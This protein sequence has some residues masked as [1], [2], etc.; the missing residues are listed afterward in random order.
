MVPGGGVSTPPW[1]HPSARASRWWPYH[2]LT[3]AASL[4]DIRAASLDMALLPLPVPVSPLLEPLPVPCVGHKAL[5]GGPQ[6]SSP[7]LPGGAAG[8]SPPL[9]NRVGARMVLP[10]EDVGL[11]RLLAWGGQLLTV[12]DG[13][14][15]WY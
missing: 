10:G 14:M 7:G 15:S 8:A 2:G 1:L 11:L 6:T 12:V 5:G 9:G 4:P 3:N 13:A